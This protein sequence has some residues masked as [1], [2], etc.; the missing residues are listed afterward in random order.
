MTA[1]ARE[2]AES[3]DAFSGLNF[4]LNQTTIPQTFTTRYILITLPLNMPS[5]T[6]LIATVMTSR[7]S[8]M[9]SPCEFL[10]DFQHF[11]L[12]TSCAAAFATSLHSWA[13]VEAVSC[14]VPAILA[15][16]PAAAGRTTAPTRYDLSQL[17]EP[18]HHLPC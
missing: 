18:T 16:A 3:V 17:S 5:L 4:I 9:I 7:Q 6:G 1:V 2:A 10:E 8:P 13:P 12:N 14:S 11:E 15:S